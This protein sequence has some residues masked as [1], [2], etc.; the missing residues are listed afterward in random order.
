MFI[1][2][3]TCIPAVLLPSAGA[4]L[5]ICAQANDEETDPVPPESRISEASDGASLADFRSSLTQCSLDVK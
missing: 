2:W 5:L 1:G 3:L 4:D